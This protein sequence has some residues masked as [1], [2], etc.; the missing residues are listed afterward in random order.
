MENDV[1][2]EVTNY[3]T[4][5]LILDFGGLS[6]RQYASLIL[7]EEFGYSYARAGKRLGLN[8][9]AFCS[10]YKRTKQKLYRANSQSNKTNHVTIP[11]TI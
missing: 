7:K 9:T 6:P 5:D 2:N 4:P 11:E 1:R 10:L 8:G 3:D